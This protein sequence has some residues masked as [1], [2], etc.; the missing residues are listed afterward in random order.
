MDRQNH[1]ATIVLLF[2]QNNAR[3]RLGHS[4][5]L[6]VCTDF[7]LVHVVFIP[8]RQKCGVSLWP[9]KKFGVGSTSNHGFFCCG[10]SFPRKLRNR[11]SV[12][13][14]RPHQSQEEPHKELVACTKGYTYVVDDVDDD[15]N[16]Y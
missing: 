8:A 14:K 15:L 13:M 5:F 10:S 1:H 16:D 4:A 11:S 12:A 2:Q 9:Y 6:G 3:R 7:L